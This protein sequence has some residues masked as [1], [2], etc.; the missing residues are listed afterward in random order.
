MLQEF[1]YDL[2]KR[3]SCLQDSRQAFYE[4]ASSVSLPH[5]LDVTE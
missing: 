5:Q 2:N 4:D 3:L 1:N